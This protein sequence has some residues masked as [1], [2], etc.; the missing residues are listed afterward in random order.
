[1]RPLRGA[2]PSDP[3]AAGRRRG[4]VV[5]AA[6][7]PFLLPWP[8]LALLIRGLIAIRWDDK[9]WP[10]AKAELRRALEVASAA[11]TGALVELSERLIVA[12][13]PVT[14]LLE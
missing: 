1:M 8:R 7:L 3:G 2:R 9:T 10:P 5:Y 14:E 6:V 12:G 4:P 13:A 11:G